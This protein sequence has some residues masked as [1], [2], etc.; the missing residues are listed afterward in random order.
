MIE[1]LTAADE[2]TL[3]G[4]PV[5]PL[6]TD[7]DRAAFRGQRCL[8]T[9]AGGS[10]GSELARQMAS[11]GPALL[12]LVDHGEHGLFQI[13]RE[14]AERWPRVR[15]DPV[16]VDVTRPAM[17]HRACGR[18]RPNVV[19]HAAAYKHVTMAE[20]AACA[21]ARVNVLGTA[22]VVAAARD[23]GARFL[24]ISSDKAARP[25]S[26]MGATKRLAELVTMCA[27]ESTFRPA[28]VR[29]GN[30][31]ASSGSFVTI[32]LDCIRHGRPIPVTDPDATRYFMTVSE[33]AS[34]VMKA[35]GMARGGE[36]FWLD[37]GEPV[38]I[39]DLVS[40]LLTLA[41]GRGCPAVPVEVIGL[42]PGE[43]RVEH[44]TTHEVPMC[45]T[46]DPR[47]WVARQRLIPSARFG[48]ALRALGRHVRDGDACQTLSTLTAIMPDYTPSDE[49]WAVARRERLY[50]YEPGGV[51]LLSA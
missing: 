42:R 47:I 26:V 40:R 39:S 20:R 17:M 35:D 8:I 25:R 49:A 23:V 5:R 4:R 15:L 21:T 32:V 33:A 51:R 3:L 19:F 13:E 7:A 6:L 29:F 22:A 11:C 48:R 30:V 2:E 37:M 10:I 36:T 24:L 38:R 27:A 41:A 16:L 34:L 9:G 14:L 46:S 50:T 45:G 1:R 44:L 31:L 43:K 18:A 12:T 28:V